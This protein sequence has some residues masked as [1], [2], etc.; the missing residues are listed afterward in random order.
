[1]INNLQ[2]L[3][4][5]AAMNVVLLHIIGTSKR[6][7]APVHA[8]SFLEGWGANGVDLF[9]VISGF[10]MVYTQSL[11]PKAALA[12]FK[13]RVIRIVPI[14][15]FLTFSIVAL[16][17][18]LPSVFSRLHPTVKHF[19]SSLFFL[20]GV[21]VEKD[22]LL[23]VGW[24][25]E[26]EMMFYSV[27]AVGIALT[28]QERLTV[29]PA[30]VL[31]ALA[32]SGLTDMIVLEFVFG[33]IV[34]TIFLRLKTLPHAGLVFCTGVLLLAL[35][36]VINTGLHRVWKWGVPAFLIVLSLCYLPQSQNRFGK[37]MGDAS[38]SIYLMQVF[39]YPA[40]YKFS[41]RFLPALPNDLLALVCLAVSVALGVLVYSII[42]KRL[43]Q[44]AR[45]LL[46]R[47]APIPASNPA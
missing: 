10:V 11:K 33:M 32:L 41:T 47:A 27:F 25:L 20:S 21:V 17:L 14:Y 26:Y 6:Y 22:P 44:G 40:F 29:L 36:L 30:V 39:A 24:T 38:Y 31:L 3:R 43:A 16:Y 34:A 19:T 18:V 9:F 13:N 8:L 42:E 12:F 23:T 7:G 15:W 45:H 46:A 35:S 5:F 4:A 1:M 37:L 2:I 28:K